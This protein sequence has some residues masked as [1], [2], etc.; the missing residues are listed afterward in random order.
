ME[1]T[2]LN[3]AIK[4]ECTVHKDGRTTCSLSPYEAL[5]FLERNT[6]AKR[7]ADS[8][9]SN[10]LTSDGLS[11]QEVSAKRRKIDDDVRLM[12]TK[13]ARGNE[14]RRKNILKAMQERQVTKIAPYNNEEVTTPTQTT[15]PYD[16][17]PEKNQIASYSRPLFAGCTFPILPLWTNEEFQRSITNAQNPQPS[18]T[19]ETFLVKKSKSKFLELMHSVYTTG[20]KIDSLGQMVRLLTINERPIMKRNSRKQK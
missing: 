11:T 3:V 2:K 9:S 17:A 6:C 4:K 13:I 16:L 18:S 19:N 1:K 7:K 8:Y 14:G 15:P 20:A 10:A 12:L 5:F